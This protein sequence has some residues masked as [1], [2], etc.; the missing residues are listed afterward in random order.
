ML[1]VKSSQRRN[2]PRINKFQRG[3]QR[4]RERKR[5][6]RRRM[7]F[8]R[9]KKPHHTLTVSPP[10]WLCIS[11]PHLSPLISFV[12]PS[13]SFLRLFLSFLSIHLPLVQ[14]L[15]YDCTHCASFS[16]IGWICMSYCAIIRAW[17]QLSVTWTSQTQRSAVFRLTC[18]QMI[19]RMAC[20]VQTAVR[21]MSIYL[22]IYLGNHSFMHL[23]NVSSRSRWCYM[24]F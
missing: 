1:W 9:A 21:N 4:E 10:L 3:E 5:F 18:F 16:E 8:W 6:G 15:I 2:T 11:L 13:L 22:A 24:L 20:S 17:P 12:P 7:R 23:W 19:F 14:A